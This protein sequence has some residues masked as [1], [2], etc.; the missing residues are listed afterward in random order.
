MEHP[1]DGPAY[2]LPSPLPKPV[3]KPKVARRPET[4]TPPLVVANSLKRSAPD[5][6]VIEE[7]GPA[8][9]KARTTNGGAFPSP[10][11]SPSKKRRLEEEGLI[12]MD[13]AQD[14]LEDDVIELD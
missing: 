6:D 4:I 3:R 2:I 5:D 11:K 8:S 14:K 10:L 13:S 7:V 9:K 1:V 12:M